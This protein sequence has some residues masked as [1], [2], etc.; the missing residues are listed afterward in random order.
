MDHSNG[1][2]EDP[3]GKF[4]IRRDGT[5]IKLG[6][7]R[8]LL[9]LVGLV[10]VACSPEQ[11]ALTTFSPGPT[12]ANAATPVVTGAAPTLTSDLS[13]SLAQ[14]ERLEISNKGNVIRVFLPGLPESI[15]EQVRSLPG[16]TKLEKYLGVLRPGDPNPFVGIGPGSELRVEG[17]L[18]SL[19]VVV[20][21]HYGEDRV[22][23]PGFSLNPFSGGGAMPG[24]AHRFSIGQ[25]FEV[26]GARLR[27]AGLFRA[28]DKSR[29]NAILLPLGTA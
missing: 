14:L 13:P 11:D 9:L 4:G 27:V 3:A 10:F 1:N 19:A 8:W 12:A 18:V 2:R 28:S 5:V 17:S 21:C 22:A 29:E 23:I 24:M 20:G 15:A 16:V 25:S 7:L 6:A 26:R